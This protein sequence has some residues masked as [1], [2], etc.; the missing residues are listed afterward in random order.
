[1]AQ[2][3]LGRAFTMGP[4]VPEDHRQSVSWLKKSALQQN[5]DA[6]F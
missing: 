3:D 5:I 6:M 4:G 1:M 2:F